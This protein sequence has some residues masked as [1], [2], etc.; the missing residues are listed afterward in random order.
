MLERGRASGGFNIQTA[1]GIIKGI[2]HR[3]RAMIQ[4]AEGY[5]YFHTKIAANKG[6]AGTG[7]AYAAA[8]SLP[9]RNAGVSRTIG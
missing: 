9:G 5:G 8:L 2:P 3:F 7:A 6:E 1:T 4:R